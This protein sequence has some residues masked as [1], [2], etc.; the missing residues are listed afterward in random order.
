M[1][2]MEDRRNAFEQQYAQNQE[3]QFR[4]DARTCRLFGLWLAEKRG[5]R[6][7]DADAFAAQVVSANL[8]E[9]GFEDVKRFVRPIIEAEN[10]D[11]DEV[12]LNAALA[13]C[14]DEAR[15]QLLAE[16]NG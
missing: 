8:E 2:Q 3:M 15:A 11:I 1:G 14:G 12:E 10:L 6:G 5:M 13:R 7:A 9:A 4:A 16:N